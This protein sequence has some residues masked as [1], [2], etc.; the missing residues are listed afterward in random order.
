MAESCGIQYDEDK[1]EADRKLVIE[2][3]N[4]E[5]AQEVGEQ[6]RQLEEKASDLPGYTLRIP[7]RTR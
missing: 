3:A 2:R 7:Q 1:R 4:T 6:M 5:L